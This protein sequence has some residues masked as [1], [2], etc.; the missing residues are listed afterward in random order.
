[1]RSTIRTVSPAAVKAARLPVQR[2]AHLAPPSPKRDSQSVRRTA[3][4][5]VKAFAGETAADASVTLS[6]AINKQ[7]LLAAAPFESVQRRVQ[8]K[9]SSM[10]A[11]LGWDAI[12]RSCSCMRRTLRS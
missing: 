10:C 4:P 6:F 5:V 11:C 9:L 1:M 3:R 2:P 8:A 12:M 7:V